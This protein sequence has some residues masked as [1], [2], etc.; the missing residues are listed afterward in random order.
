[1]MR[2][3]TLQEHTWFSFRNK[4]DVLR[5]LLTSRMTREPSQRQDGLPAKAFFRHR[6][7][8]KRTDSR[9]S[10]QCTPLA[11]FFEVH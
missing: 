1:M 2:I 4:T 11:A 8:L 5:I 3:S 7:S 9:E 10:L 6:S